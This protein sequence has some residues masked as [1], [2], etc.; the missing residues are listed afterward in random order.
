MLA[1]LSRLNRVQRS[2]WFKYIASGLV[3]VLAIGLVTA[4]AINRSNAAQDR[5]T[6]AW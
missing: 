2:R 4:V 5:F 6:V 1:F 3:L